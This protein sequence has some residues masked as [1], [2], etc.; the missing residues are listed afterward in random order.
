VA[1]GLP[2]ERT[3]DRVAL[4]RAGSGTPYGHIEEQYDV[5]LIQ[6]VDQMDHAHRSRPSGRYWRRNLRECGSEAAAEDE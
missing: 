2:P 3:C 4:S 1:D 5:G 6:R